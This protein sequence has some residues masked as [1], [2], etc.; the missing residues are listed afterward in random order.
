MTRKRKRHRTE[1]A[2]IGWEPYVNDPI[3]NGKQLET[4]RRAVIA[5]EVVR[6][7]SVDLRRF[8]TVADKQRVHGHW[9]PAQCVLESSQ[10][11]FVVDVDLVQDTAAAILERELVRLRR[12][13]AAGDL[14]SVALPV[15]W[16]RLWVV[17]DSPRVVHAERLTERCTL[18][19]TRV[20]VLPLSQ[21]P[22][23]RGQRAVPALRLLP[24]DLLRAALDA[25]Q[26]HG[27]LRTAAGTQHPRDIGLLQARLRPVDPASVRT[28]REQHTLEKLRLVRDVHQ[29]APHGDKLPA[30]MQRLRCSRRKAEQ[31]VRESQERLQWGLAHERSKST[32]QR[33][34]GGK[35]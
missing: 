19:V 2:L 4:C 24:G 18:Q 34:K 26:L 20:T 16:S 25:A 32:K 33:N 3:V 28:V 23:R 30:V 1:Y 8:E 12:A 11:R 17:K 10:A 14:R 6:P 15:T 13:A 35:T 29:A 7:S 27:V 21:Q 22:G 31:L 5:G 9:L